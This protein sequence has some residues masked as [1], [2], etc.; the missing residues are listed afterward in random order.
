MQNYARSLLPVYSR[1]SN[2]QQKI[3][4]LLL[5]LIILGPLKSAAQKPEDAKVNV[6]FNNIPLKQAFKEIEKKAN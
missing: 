6:D 5:T 3:V 4:Y 2:F 1:L